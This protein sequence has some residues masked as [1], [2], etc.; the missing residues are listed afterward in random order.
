[1]R[2]SFFFPLHPQT[3]QHGSPRRNHR[4]TVVPSHEM[5]DFLGFSAMMTAVL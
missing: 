3:C 2:I 1:M 4:A 5:P